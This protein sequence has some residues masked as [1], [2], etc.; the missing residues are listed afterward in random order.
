METPSNVK[1][2]CLYAWVGEDEFGSGVVGVKQALF[3]TGII[4][5]VAIDQQKIDKD[6]IREGLQGQANTYGKTIR[7]CKFVFVEEVVTLEPST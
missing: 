3:P 6:F 7:L 5:L 4:P 1:E 2:V